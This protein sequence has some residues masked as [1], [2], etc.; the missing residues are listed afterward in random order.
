MFLWVMLFVVMVLPCHNVSSFAPDPSRQYCQSQLGGLS[1]AGV[2][3]GDTLSYFALGGSSG[4]PVDTLPLL[5][6]PSVLCSYRP[7][8]TLHGMVHRDLVSLPVVS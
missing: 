2:R 7:Y 5:L 6:L 4:G 8:Y 1:W 3:G